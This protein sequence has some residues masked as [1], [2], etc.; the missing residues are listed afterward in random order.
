MADLVNRAQ[1][2][3]ELP[4]LSGQAFIQ[5]QEV[6]TSS[7]RRIGASDYRLAIDDVAMLAAVNAFA[8]HEKVDDDET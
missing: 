5:S 2:R 3:K 7:F 8:T 6:L 4:R 1:M